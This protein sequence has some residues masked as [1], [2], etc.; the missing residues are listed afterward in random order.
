MVPWVL[1]HRQIYIYIY[2]S[3]ASVLLVS[4]ETVAENGA[5]QEPQEQRQTQMG[6]S[7]SRRPLNFLVSF[8]LIFKCR[9]GHQFDTTPNSG[10]F[11]KSPRVRGCNCFNLLVLSDDWC[12]LFTF[13]PTTSLSS[14]RTSKRTTSLDCCSFAKDTRSSPNEA[15]QLSHLNKK[16]LSVAEVFMNIWLD[17]WTSTWWLALYWTH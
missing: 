8:W 3:N 9:K 2:I 16:C 10:P 4:L 14:L 1:T 17:L 13:I 15:T 11:N 6:I 12:L 5:Q 7:Q